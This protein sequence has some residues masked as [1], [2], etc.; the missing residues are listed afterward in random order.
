MNK[1]IKFVLMLIIVGIFA[2]FSGYYFKKDRINNDLV[3]R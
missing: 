2:G 1:N 3:H